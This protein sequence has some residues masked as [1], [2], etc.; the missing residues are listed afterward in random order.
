MDTARLEQLGL[1]VRESA[2]GI[3]ATL[4]LSA[5]LV[6]PMTRQPLAQ[7]TFQVLGE[8]LVPSAPPE[9]VGLPPVLVSAVEGAA[10]IEALVSDSFSEAIMHLQRRSS[11][12]QV[13]GLTP[14]VDPAR[15][16]LSARVSE[17]P[18]QFTL[19]ADRQGHFR[20]VRAECDG[21]LL[22]TASAHRFELSEFR[23]RAALV[24][25]LMALFDEATHRQPS[26][27]PALLRYT[28]LAEAFGPAALVPPTSGVELL[29]QFEVEGRPYRFAAA[30]VAGRTFRALLA[31][32]QGNKVWAGR[33]N[34]KDF[35]GIVQFVAGLLN[36][37]PEAVRLV[38]PDTSQ[39]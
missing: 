36:V 39:E 37:P 32:A 22:P 24:G 6:N 16:E 1:T 11:E 30:R 26:A 25:Y 34:L 21:E 2:T 3:E 5:V 18:F 13:L 10:N 38:V 7:V 23:E 14:H 8:R 27:P 19:V 17:G 4:D 15:L 29:A 35:P 12:L 9:V 31:G 33:F 28:E 20:V